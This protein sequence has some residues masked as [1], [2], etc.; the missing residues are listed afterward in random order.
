MKRS[1]E[2][3]GA[4]L[5]LALVWWPPSDCPAKDCAAGLSEKVP[6]IIDKAAREVRLLATVQRKAFQ[7][8][9]FK[10]LPGHH[11]VTW[12]QGRKGHEALFATFAGDVEVYDALIALGAGPG[13]NLT[14]AVWDERN[15][16]NSSAPDTRVQGTPVDAFVWWLGLDDPL[17]LASVLNDP[18]GKGI[19]LR[20]GGQKDLIP[21]WKSGCII[22]L[23]SCPGGKISNRQYTIRDYVQGRATFTAN[24]AIVPKEEKRVVVIIRLR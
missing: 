1:W 13:D 5:V 24:K 4:L 14:Q 21:V 10:Q 23:Q 22:C 11:A 15:N 2:K 17:P 18:S 19:D 16:P 7:A 8:G 3:I 12:R 6:M 20:F 9:W